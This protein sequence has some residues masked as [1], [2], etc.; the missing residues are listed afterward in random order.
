MT[1]L[2]F[3]RKIAEIKA[4]M[5]E[6]NTVR[7][8]SWTCIDCMTPRSAIRKGYRC[9]ACSELHQTERRR[10][11]PRKRPVYVD[12]VE[13]SRRKGAWYDADPDIAAYRAEKAKREV[14]AASD[15]ASIESAIAEARAIL[16]AESGDPIRKRRAS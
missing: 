7:V 9:T 13:Q 10:L 3:D 1:S 12:P 5:P 14:R 2:W 16:H 8:R 11:Q 6:R 15:A 4:S